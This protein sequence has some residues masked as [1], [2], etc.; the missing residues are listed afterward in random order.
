MKKWHVA[1]T[2]TVLFLVGGAPRAQAQAVYTEFSDE[3][4]WA[5]VMYLWAETIEANTGV[6]DAI[7]PIELSMRSRSCPARGC[8]RSKASG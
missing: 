8:L 6:G 4:Q 3:W 5:I 1:L 7:I 2:M